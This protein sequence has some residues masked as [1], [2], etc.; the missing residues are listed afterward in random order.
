MIV[1]YE[2]AHQRADYVII[3]LNLSHW[4]PYSIHCH[5]NDNAPCTTRRFAEIYGRHPNN[6]WKGIDMIKGVKFATVPVAD[7]DRAL[8]FYTKKL[9]FRIITDAP[10]SDEQRW[11]E[12]GI[13]NAQTSIVLFTMDEHKDRV[14]TSAGFTFW[15]DDVQ[16]TYEDLKAKGVELLGEPQTMD[17]GTFVVF[18][19][20]EGNSFVLGTK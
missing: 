12:L 9:G 2:I 8:E 5:G 11:I 16:G 17:W 14:G 15:T 1:T 6:A 20:S 19:D 10:F 3:Q 18:K 13:P 7:Q 4:A